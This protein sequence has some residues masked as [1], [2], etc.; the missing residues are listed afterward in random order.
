MK[1]RKAII[2]LA[3][4]WRATVSFAE[5]TPDVVFRVN[6]SP[7]E[8]VFKEG[9]S[10]AGNDRDLLHYVSGMSLANDNEAY[11]ATT[12]SLPNAID[13]CSECNEEALTGPLYI[14]YIRPT[15][16]FYS[17]SDSIR[18][19]QNVLPNPDVRREI[20]TIWR[21]TQGEMIYYWAARA[22]ISPNQI[23]GVRRF[24]WNND[25]PTLSA[26]EPNPNYVYRD[27]EVSAYPMPIHNAT[28]EAAFVAPQ[29]HGVGFEAAGMVDMLHGPQFQRHAT[30]KSPQCRA[31]QR[32]T[33]QE[34]RTKNLG[35]LIAAGILMDSTS[36]Q[37]R[38]VPG[39]DEL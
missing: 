38:S 27:P 26:L 17:V 7:P 8:T 10:A 18:F 22:A 5:D 37:L 36:G 6:L 15:D 3:A 14:Y 31:L 2:A 24:Y 19:A 39:H 13:L 16:N 32:L 20:D 33:F 29:P 23:M 11:V 21:A 1:F 25:N 9:F 28:I 4:T 30:F 12:S 34:L 35:R